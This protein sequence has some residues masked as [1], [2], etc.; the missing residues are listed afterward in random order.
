MLLTANY[1]LKKPE[2]TD[3][4]NVDDFNSN[5]DIIDE[6]LKNL[7]D[8]KAAK[9]VVTTSA[10]GLMSAIDKAKLNGIA[11]NANNYVHPNNSSTRHVTDAEKTAWNGKA[12]GN[13]THTKAQITD[14]PTALKNPTAVKVQLNGGTTEG[15]NQFTYDGSVA[16]T[17][18]VTPAN[19][20]ALP[21][22][23]KAADSSKLN[24]VAESTS[25]TAN[26][27][28]KRDSN[29]DLTTRFFKSSYPN[30]NRMNGAIDYR[31][32]DSTDN[33]IRFCSDVQAILE[34]LG[35]NKAKYELLG[36][37][38]SFTINNPNPSANFIRLTFHCS[39]MSGFSTLNFHVNEKYLSDWAMKGSF[40][41]TIELMKVSESKYVATLKISCKERNSDGKYSTTTSSTTVDASE[42]ASIRI[43]HSQSSS[44]LEG[45][46]YTLEYF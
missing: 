17:I 12:E 24:G 10:N 15:S 29:G 18:N 34:W 6:K 41:A 44:N 46:A 43:F 19:I 25:G 37:A 23:G 32:N 8:T 3:I 7:E 1:K 39:N 42:I 35:T 28:A 38:N 26:T 20:G 27:I 5:A 16:K 2:G 4:V 22:K 9:D 13:H 11:N 21:S 33:N 30:Q 45:C 40:G 14:M 36:T 31:V